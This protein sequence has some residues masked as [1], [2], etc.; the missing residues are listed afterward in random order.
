MKSLVTLIAGIIVLMTSIHCPGQNY[1]KVI[2]AFI[3]EYYME[4]TIFGI[5]DNYQNIKGSPYLSDRFITGVITMKDGNVYEGPLRYNCY[6]DQLEFKTEE[7]EVYAIAKPEIIK[8]VTIEKDSFLYVPDQKDPGKGNFYQVV[9]EGEYSLLM[10]HRTILKD[11]EPARA[12]AEATPAQFVRK[13]VEYLLYHEQTGLVPVRSKRDLN[14]FAE[15]IDE[16]LKS[17]VKKRKIKT[18][19]KE[20][21]VQ[22]TEYLN[23]AVK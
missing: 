5:S 12:Y 8:K 20:D 14:N 2:H 18:N 10:K 4:K 22:I 6:A 13:D 9:T 16:S 21:M 7:G 19:D 23:A 17:F 3:D 11:A 15:T 1:R